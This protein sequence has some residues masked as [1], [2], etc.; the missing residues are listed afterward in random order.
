MRNGFYAAVLCPSGQ[1]CQNGECVT[2][3][4]EP[5]GNRGTNTATDNAS[6]KDA[7][8]RATGTDDA[9]GRGHTT[10]PSSTL[11]VV[12]NPTSQTTP[13]SQPVGTEDATGHG[14]SSTDTGMVFPTSRY[15][16]YLSSRDPNASLDPNG[17]GAMSTPISYVP[18]PVT[19]TVTDYVTVSESGMGHERSNSRLGDQLDQVHRCPTCRNVLADPT[20]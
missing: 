12:P 2:L 18:C 9:I 16:P 3:L 8:T 5:T 20:V 11:A 7:S 1:G 17:R 6:S 10:S 4:G 15:P 19:Q 14:P 13:A